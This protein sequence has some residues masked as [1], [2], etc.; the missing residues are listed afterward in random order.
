MPRPIAHSGI[1]KLIPSILII[2]G[3]FLSMVWGAVLVFLAVRLLE[4]A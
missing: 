2:L 1:A 4:F 3:L